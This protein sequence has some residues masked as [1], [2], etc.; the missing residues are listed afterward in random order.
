VIHVVSASV[1]AS[2]P[3]GP[4]ALTSGTLVR[5]AA[6]ATVYLV[7]GLTSKIPF[8]SFDIP[9]SI[10]ITGFSFVD[11][12][13]LAGYPTAKATMGYGITCGS[14][15]YVAA[16]GTLRA[17]DATTKPLYP[18]V[19]TPLDSYTCALLRIGT[20]ATKFL[21]TPNGSIYLLDSGT[22]RPISSMARFAQLG[23]SVGYVDVTAGLAATIPTGPAA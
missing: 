13:V 11:S 15:D 18:L 10:G 19:Y 21:R 22:K 20:P 6:D 9:A 8:S 7:N 17:L 14:T 4:T 3:M 5:S 2:L 1:I 12:A 16:A 23:G